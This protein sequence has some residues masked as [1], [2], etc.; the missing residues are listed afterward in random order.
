MCALWDSGKEWHA[1]L[2]HLQGRFEHGTQQ[3]LS[4]FLLH[5]HVFLYIYIY[6]FDLCIW[7]VYNMGLGSLS[8]GGNG[9]FPG[10]EETME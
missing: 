8:H 3:N 9:V 5:I 2:G 1:Q 10:A 4:H 6:K 7:E